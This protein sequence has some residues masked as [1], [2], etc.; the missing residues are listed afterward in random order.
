MRNFREYVLLKDNDMSRALD[1]RHPEDWNNDA[2]AFL[3]KAARMFA[4]Q[5]PEALMG[6]LDDQGDDQIKELIKKV[7]AKKGGL[8]LGSRG[9][10]NIGGDDL[11]KFKTP[12]ADRAG[13]PEEGE[14][15]GAG[16]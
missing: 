1:G 4:D 7:K 16:Y 13:S 2:T 3:Y 11:E 12:D 15:E 8:N 14:G 9:L 5:K 6:F 10:G